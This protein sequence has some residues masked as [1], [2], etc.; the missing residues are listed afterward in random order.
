VTADQLGAAGAMA[1]LLNDAV[2]P[3]LLQ[4][5]EGSPVLVHAGPFANIAHGNSSIVADRVGLR[6]LGRDDGGYLITECGFGSDCGFEKFSHVKCRTAGL[7]PDCAVIVATVKALKEHGGLPKTRRSQAPPSPAA[8]MA[9]LETG[10][11]NLAA[12]IAIVRRFG[13]PAVVA[14]NR[15]PTDTD[16]EMARVLAG[17]QQAGAT[18]AAPSEV[19][20]HGGHG[21][22]QLT[23]AVIAACEADNDFHYLYELDTPVPEKIHTIAT[24]VYGADGVEMSDAAAAQI[25]RFSDLGFGDLPVIMAKTPQSLSH[26]PTLKN[27]PRGF[28]LPV[29]DV[30]LSAG[31]GF[32]YALCG[33]IMT[34]PGLPSAPAFF[35]IDVD[36]EGRVTGLS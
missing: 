20:A 29:R 26:D 9:C 27:V 31:A 1:A 16:E 32:L 11:D 2:Q 12:H 25:Q 7:R 13:V 14:V 22:A 36:A 18:A 5:L 6:A 30:R 28:H 34:M 10:L 8:Q 35:G 15:Y 3:N 33:D 24:Q 21:G 23:E 17:A 4:T 19:W